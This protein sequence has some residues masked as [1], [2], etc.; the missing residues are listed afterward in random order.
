QRVDPEHAD[1]GGHA[2]LFENVEGSRFPVAIN[3]FG[4]YHRMEMAL[5][6]HEEGHTTGGFEAIAGRIAELTKPEPPASLGD[7]IVK[8]RHLAPLLRIP[9]KH[10]RRGISQEVVLTGSAIN[11]LELP[12]IKCWPLDGNL[13]AVG[14]PTPAGQPD[15]SPGQGRFITFAGMHTIHA[16]DAG[17]PRPPSRNIGMYRAQV[18]DRTRLAMHWHVHHDGARH[19]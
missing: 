1:L 3:V 11:L 17:R 14:Y 6:C 12:I 7:L 9:P 2:L 16:D 19:W 13:E 10:R 8:A 5:G 18:I 15:T 4:S